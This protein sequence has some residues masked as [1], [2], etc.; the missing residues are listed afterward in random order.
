MS[1]LF[2]GHGADGG[3]RVELKPSRL[4]THGVILGMTGSGKTG[5]GLV[6]LEELADAGV[7]LI[8]VDPKGDLSNL[9]LL[10]PDMDEA[11]FKPWVEDPDDAAS[12][13]ATWKAGLERTG[14]STE[15]VARLREKM[16]LTVYTPGST[17]GVGVDVLGAF[18]RPTGA[19]AGDPE[20]RAALVQSSV[21]GLLGLAGRAPDPVRDPAHVVLSRIVSE[22]WDRGEDPDLATLVM[23][24]VEP[25][26]EKVGVFPVDRFFPPDDRMDIA[27]ALNAVLASPAFSNWKQGAPLDMSRL[28]ERGDKTR[29]SVFHLAHL[30]DVQRTFFLSILLGEVLAH[31]RQMPGSSELRGLLYFDEVAGYL[32]PHP[33][34]PPTKAPL[35]T[36]MKQARAVGVGVVLSTQNPVDLDYKALSNAGVWAIGRLQTQQDRDRVLKGMGRPELDDTV[37][38]LKKRE[39]VLFDAKADA[40]L[41]FKTRFARCYLRGPLTRVELSALR[42]SPL[43]APADDGKVAGG[44][45]MEAPLAT[46]APAPINAAAADPSASPAADD[47]LLSQPQGE[48]DR[49][50]LDGRALGSAAV[51]EI[52]AQHREPV[53][54]D[55]RVVYRPA[56]W[57]DLALRFDEDRI[58]FILD[59]RERRIWFPL[60]DSAPTEHAALP[61][62]DA[63]LLESPEPNARFAPVPAWMDEAKELKALQKRVIDDVYRNETTGRFVHSK[64]R[65]NAR[66]DETKEQFIERVRAVAAERRD[67][68]LAKLHESVQRKIDRLEERERT[69]EARVAEL[70]GDLRSSQTQELVDVGASIFSMFAGRGRMTGSKVSKT[71]RGRKRSSG[72]ARRLTSA[73]EKLEAI[74]EQMV[75]LAEDTE[76]KVAELEAE[77]E[78][79]VADIEEKEVRLEK[80]DIRV[81]RFGLLWIPVG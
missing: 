39:F 37:E 30:D 24:L 31:T 2:L 8:L 81:D 43:T 23:N 71:M 16:S 47:G 57:A 27:M 65:M 50:F 15:D 35:L 19:A 32:P 60:G 25:P 46:G 73:E 67:E 62:P 13:A 6:L 1:K 75:E 64:L 18:R 34:N 52:V 36:M 29:V 56:L 9:A 72:K 76:D 78:T 17:A 44:R 20:A 45:A 33:R 69:T 68:K 26:F 22:A 4:T 66:G 79:M 41:H 53:R 21:S 12:T 5:L 48:G 77:A 28:L 49:W 70:S 63:A 59:R 7:P 58:G 10:F 80:S 40:P 3:E 61:L 74:R 55:G 38:A 51:K 14:L 54:D 11:A 42:D